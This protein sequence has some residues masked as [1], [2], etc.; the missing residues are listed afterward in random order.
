MRHARLAAFC[1]L[2]ISPFALAKGGT[3]YMLE[4]I[5][6]TAS[7]I[8]Q[9]LVQTIR[10]TTV[11]TATEIRA[12]LAPDLP[13]LL[14]Q[15]AGI[16][17][18]QSGGMGT[19]T[20]L[21]L[22]G[23]ESDHTLVLLD[24]MR[25]ASASTGL[26]AL[27]QIML[28]DVERIEIVR[29]NVSA[30]YGSDAIGGV[31][32]IFTRKGRGAPAGS[33]RAGVGSYGTYTAAAGY[34]GGASSTRFYLGLSHRDSDGYSA[35]RSEFIPSGSFAI[36]DTDKDGY[37]NTTFTLNLA[38]DLAA[39]HT[40]SFTGRA[41][42]G[43]TEYDGTSQ[44]GSEQDLDAFALHSDNVIGEHWQSRLSVS[45]SRDVLDNFLDGAATGFV[46]TRNRQA[47]WFN[48]L[49]LTKG[50][51]L[52]LGLG[53]LQQRLSSD[54]TYSRDSRLVRHGA[55]GYVGEVG[56]H[57]VQLNVRHDDYSD[58]GGH[59]TGLVGYTFALAPAWRLMASTGNAYRAPSF[60]DLYNAAWGGN[61]ALHPEKAHS[62]EMGVQYS[63][64]VLGARLVHFDTRTK[65]LIVYQWP[66][67]LLNLARARS[68]GWEASLSGRLAGFDLR[69]S[70]TWQDPR[71]EGT[72]FPL[73]RRA[74]RLGSVS[75]SRG[76]GPWDL[77]AEIKASGSRAD[78]HAT[79]FSRIYNPGY[80]VL[81]LSG[82]YRLGED[83][84]VE[85]RLDNLLDEDYSLAHGYNTPGRSGFVQLEWRL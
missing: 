82:R 28:E 5:V 59:T 1:G 72:G 54:Q 69:A 29:G 27:D 20:S 81:N 31:I 78:M 64:P 25:I 52:T 68:D 62:W 40:L 17:I 36:G 75:A 24:G 66:T 80:A 65:D 14:R 71:D 37:R 10:H 53:V 74:E 85:A 2:V 51:T 77:T 38:Q 33:L 47:E 30:L 58:F 44:N 15:Q 55:L 34:G 26:T 11:L 41:S 83:I 18:T 19:Q 16:E 23:S 4:D 6:V 48:T 8:E 67:G 73:L 57:G 50:H 32:Q 13:N 60:N 84:T 35:A 22:R 21:F 49:P 9:P 45:Q 56:Q 79:N 70:L 76:F 46:H 63:G 12:S 61:P 42:Q 7:R 39:G 3:P 43:K